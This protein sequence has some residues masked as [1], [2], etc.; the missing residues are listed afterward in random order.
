VASKTA[1]AAG[2]VFL[3]LNLWRPDELGK[4]DNNCDI[5]SN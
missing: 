2:L 3:R 5:R 4:F 1:R